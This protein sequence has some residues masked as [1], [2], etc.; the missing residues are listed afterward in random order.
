MEEIQNKKYRT[1]TGILY[2]DTESY[3][4]KEVILNLMSFKKWCY[5]EHKP[6][7]KEKKYHTHFVIKLD[8]PRTKSGI[9]KLLG[10]PQKHI[11]DVRNERAILRYLTHIDDD[12]VKTK[13]K[14]SD[15]KSSR[16]Y[17]RHIHKAYE[18]LETED[19]IIGNIYKQIDLLLT[20][21][22]NQYLKIQPLLIQWVNYNCYDT[23]YKRYR[24]EF[25]SYLTMQ[26]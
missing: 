6:E 16:Y 2:K 7:E 18:E 4:Y 1:F 11:Q 3:N 5:I 22:E 8:N 12:E 19:E 21:Y 17:E 13:Y 20:I 26:L 10:I 23:I 24:Q 14:F 9:T 15:I 25:N